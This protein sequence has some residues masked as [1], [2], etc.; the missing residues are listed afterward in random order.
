MSH[1]DGYW[2]DWV[3]RPGDSV[4]LHLTGTGATK[5][6]LRPLDG[7]TVLDANNDLTWSGDL[8]KRDY[9]FG[10]V[11]SEDVFVEA[12]AEGWTFKFDVRIETAA[13]QLPAI[14]AVDFDDGYKIEVNSVN[15][16]I[17][18]RAND[19][20]LQTTIEIGQW[21]TVEISIKQQSLSLWIGKSVEADS[22]LTIPIESIEGSLSCVSF[23]AL[24][25]NTTHFRV[26]S[27]R[28]CSN[29]R[30]KKLFE[31]PTRPTQRNNPVWGL[32]DSTGG[33]SAI[34]FHPED[35]G[36]VK[37]PATV[38]FELPIDLEP[39]VYV[40]SCVGNTQTTNIPLFV[41]PKT[42]T[43]KVAVLMSTFTYLAYAGYRQSTEEVTLG[44]YR[45]VT[46]REV[47]LTDID[48]RLAKTIEPG[49]SLYDRY[50]DG[51]AT[52]VAS[53]R[54]PL[55]DF[56]PGHKHWLTGT[57]RN[58]GS[59]L[60]LLAWLDRNGTDIDV[61][62]DDWLHNEGKHVLEDY[63]IVITGS[64]PEYASLSILESLTNFVGT[65]G[66]LLYLGGNGFDF[67][68]EPSAAS[69]ADTIEIR[70]ST[71]SWRGANVADDRLSNGCAAGL[72][73]SAGRTANQ[74]TGVGYCTQG[75]G[76]AP[77]YLQL[78]DART[79]DIGKALFEGIDSNEIIGDFGNSLGG[80][81]GDEID[82]YDIAK[83]TPAQTIRLA[84]SEGFHTHHMMDVESGPLRADITYTPH[85]S[86]GSVFAVGSMNWVTSLIADVPNNN[87]ATLTVNALNLAQ[88]RA[89]SASS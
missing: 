28:L 22:W 64:H 9:N 46:D 44:N 35:I 8:V 41:Q 69:P 71:G 16:Q 87:V 85:E 36:D 11:A 55:I 82:C 58:F 23:G 1:I 19:K 60:E 27:V 84:S 75:W 81:A 14:A 24:K 61:I 54:H 32:S 34:R 15:D 59:D 49:W 52:Y 42:P 70:R 68:A 53:R 20:C 47:N 37:W 72:W 17:H 86:G 10:S 45:D 78:P 39:G 40:G 7:N 80:A 38:S 50:S 88:Q 29:T 83:G 77:G 56:V 89:R 76:P 33:Y 67:V 51:T 3:A 74:L 65:G 43:N 73:S 48:K 2:Y 31:E 66:H 4:A 13:E 5:V 12:D 21:E 79:T 57:T 63:D 6:E 25:L 26:C 18:I 62:T 30:E